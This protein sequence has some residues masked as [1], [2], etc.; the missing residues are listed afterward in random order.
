[1]RRKTLEETYYTNICVQHHAGYLPP[2]SN[3]MKDLQV[4]GI[5]HGQK[6][7]AEEILSGYQLDGRWLNAGLGS[8]MT[9]TYPSPEKTTN[10]HV[11]GSLGL[12]HQPPK[13]ENYEVEDRTMILIFC[14]N[15]CKGHSEKPRSQ[16]SLVQ[17]VLQHGRSMCIHTCITC[18]A[19]WNAGWT[20]TSW[21]VDANHTGECQMRSGIWFNRSNRPAR[22]WHRSTATYEDVFC[23]A[24]LQVGQVESLRGPWKLPKRPYIAP[25]AW[26]PFEHWDARSRRQSGEKTSSSLITSPKKLVKWILQANAKSFGLASEELYPR[27]ATSRNSIPWRW[28]C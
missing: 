5:I 26:I 25:N 10:Q 28:K 22:R 9:L 17:W 16:N 3:A 7:G 20:V 21:G 11:F 14:K 24:V 18:K 15:S 19:I 2:S 23:N 1:M 27:C 8:R 6:E 13:M 4:R 12:Q